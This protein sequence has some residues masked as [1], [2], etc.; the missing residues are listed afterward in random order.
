MNQPSPRFST[1][2]AATVRVEPPPRRA[3]G[4]AGR[5]G[6]MPRSAPVRTL[7]IS[8]PNGD[9]RLGD[10]MLVHDL[11]MHL[12]TM[13]APQASRDHSAVRLG[14]FVPAP[15]IDEQQHCRF[16]PMLLLEAMLFIVQRFQE[17]GIVHFALEPPVEMGDAEDAPGALSRLALLERAGATDLQVNPSPDAA[18]LGSFVVQG[19]WTYSGFNLAALAG[20]LF[21]Q[22]SIYARMMRKG[23]DARQMKPASRWL[24]RQWARVTP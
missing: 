2:T 1:G 21:E 13:Q 20:E 23:P 22:R 15:V 24:E 6:S 11:A 7:F 12:G 9:Y 10:P 16:A 5:Q 18:I 3:E 17:V 8:G 14:R 19:A 4:R